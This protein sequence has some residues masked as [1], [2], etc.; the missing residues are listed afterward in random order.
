MMISLISKFGLQNCPDDIQHKV[1]NKVKLFSSQLIWAKSFR[2]LERFVQKYSLW[3]EEEL[4]LSEEVYGLIDATQSQEISVPGP[5]RG[6][7]VKLFT[8]C[9]RKIKMRKVQQLLEPQGP[10]E[11]AFAAE[12]SLQAAGKRDTAD[13]FKELSAASPTRLEI[14]TLWSTLKF[15]R[16]SLRHVMGDDVSRAGNNKCNCSIQGLCCNSVHE[17]ISMVLYACYST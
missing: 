8:E 9:S 3:L 12:A 2:H 11:I 16:C 15:Q 13:I 10:E 7:P 4:K 14:C 5:S 1:K 6:H 17:P